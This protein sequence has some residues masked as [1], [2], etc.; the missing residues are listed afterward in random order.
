MQDVTPTGIDYPLQ[1]PSETLLLSYM[2]GFVGVRYL[3]GGGN[4]LTGFDCSGLALVYLEAAGKW[5]FGQRTN[6]QGIHDHFEK[7]SARLIKTLPTM[8]ALPNQANGTLP[9]FGDLVFFGTA[10]QGVDHVGLCLNAMLMLEAGGGDHTTITEE[11]AAK[12]NAFVKV[13]PM[14]YRRDFL[15]VLRP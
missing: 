6:A 5:P 9:E 15:C 10:A 3:F 13:M 14:R 7:T 11:D 12:R 8:Q 2:L 4:P 1:M